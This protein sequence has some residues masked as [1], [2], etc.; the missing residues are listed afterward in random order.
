[1]KQDQMILVAAVGFA[2]LLVA[3]K[4]GWLKSSPLSAS[5]P[6]PTF[7]FPSASA[8]RGYRPSDPGAYVTTDDLIAGVSENDYSTIAPGR[9]EQ[10]IDDALSLPGFYSPGIKAW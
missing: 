9:F 7:Q 2:A 6:W 8:D 1:M 3:Q 4:K 10:T 5:V